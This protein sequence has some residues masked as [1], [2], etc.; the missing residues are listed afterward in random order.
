MIDSQ[1]SHLDKYIVCFGHL[2]ICWKIKN[3]KKDSAVSDYKAHSTGQS[4]L[5]CWVVEPHFHCW[6]N[7]RIFISISLS[8]Y[9]C[10]QTSQGAG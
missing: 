3:F 2:D 10:Q 9:L 6:V 1:N 5:H 8:H 4:P 7:F